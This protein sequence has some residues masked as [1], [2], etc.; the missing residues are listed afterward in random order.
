MAIENKLSSLGLNLLLLFSLIIWCNF[1]R[2]LDGIWFFA[3]GSVKSHI[4]FCMI[5]Y[6]EPYQTATNTKAFIF[7]H[8]HFL[9][10]TQYNQMYDIALYIFENRD[11][12]QGWQ[13]AFNQKWI[14]R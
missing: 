4:K 8:I 9:Q 14:F 5:L 12:I 3:F 2:N 11:I 7:V 1:H 6:M 10:A 13:V